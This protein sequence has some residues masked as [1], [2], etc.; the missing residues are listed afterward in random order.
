MS[1]VPP[2]APR[3]VVFDLDGVL[4]D[5]EPLWQRVER[6]VVESFGGSWTPEAQEALLGKGPMDA[7]VTLAR[8]LDVADPRE[9]DRRM[10][11]AAVTAFRGG[12]P[13]RPGAAALVGALRGRLPLAVATNSRRVLADLALSSAGLEGVADAVVA[14]E[15]TPRPKPA[16]DPYARA[17]ELVG[18]EPRLAVAFEDSPLGARSAR[19]AG[20]WVIGCPSLPSVRVPDAHALVASLEEVD[21]DAL[22]RG[23]PGAGPR[24]PGGED[25]L[26][27]RPA[28]AS[29]DSAAGATA[30]RRRAR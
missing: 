10:R 28:S 23:R 19:A 7:A 4:V 6:S 16:P 5:S 1:V 9:V 29:T 25:G 11:A 3:A 18:V 24:P 13:V 17:C 14:A 12:V 22:L 20:L 27:A 8:L 26:S 2:F 15:D 30:P 21:P